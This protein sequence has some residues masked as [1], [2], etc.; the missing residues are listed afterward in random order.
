MVSYIQCMTREEET[1]AIHNH[2]G[3][4]KY[5]HTYSVEHYMTGKGGR[6]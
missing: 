1:F 5:W 3:M 4:E 6:G 2:I